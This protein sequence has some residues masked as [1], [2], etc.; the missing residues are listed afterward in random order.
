MKCIECGSHD[1]T[2]DDI[3][4]EKVCDSCGLVL[5]VTPLEETSS[6]TVYENRESIGREKVSR[7]SSLGS[8]ISSSG[9]TVSYTHL[10]LP[11]K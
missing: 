11:T 3:L 6:N 1:S 7:L 8:M 10:T 4:G 2:F 5:M 9:P